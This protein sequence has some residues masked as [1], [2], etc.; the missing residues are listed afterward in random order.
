MTKKSFK[1]I[2]STEDEANLN[3]AS[4]IPRP[5]DTLD[6]PHIILKVTEIHYTKS[7]FNLQTGSTVIV[8]RARRWRRCFYGFNYTYSLQNPTWDGKALGLTIYDVENHRHVLLQFLVEYK[9]SPQIDSLLSSA[10][11]LE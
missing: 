7:T 11:V 4:L 10:P 1:L 2:E 9:M 5:H 6:L 3:Q 8:L